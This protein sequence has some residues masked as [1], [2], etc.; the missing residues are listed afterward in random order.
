MDKVKKPCNS[1]GKSYFW[2]VVSMYVCGPRQR[3]YGLT[4][5]IDIRYSNVCPPQLGV[6]CTQ[7]RQLL[8]AG[9]F[10]MRP[11]SEEKKLLPRRRK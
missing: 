3:L 6:R 5:F 8:K 9:A 2:D 4:D 1:E 10:Q 11:P 7:T